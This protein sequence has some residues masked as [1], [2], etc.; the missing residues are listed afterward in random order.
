MRARTGVVQ[1]VDQGLDVAQAAGDGDDGAAGDIDHMGEPGPHVAQPDIQRPSGLAVAGLPGLED[2]AAGERTA[3]RPEMQPFEGA[4][5][6]DRVEAARQAAAATKEWN[7]CRDRRR[8]FAMRGRGEDDER[9]VAPFARHAAQAGHDPAAEHETP[10]DPG[11]EDD[12]EDVAV[13]P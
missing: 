5:A 1:R 9:G 12:A 13:A 7:L 11:A 6:R 3:S 8:V 10:A 2:R 4:G